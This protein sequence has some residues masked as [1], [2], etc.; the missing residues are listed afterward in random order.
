LQNL[1]KI[2]QIKEHPTDGEEIER[3]LSVAALFIATNFS[4]NGLDK[5]LELD[6]WPP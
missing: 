4:V 3:L 5:R 1:L 2:G 6:R